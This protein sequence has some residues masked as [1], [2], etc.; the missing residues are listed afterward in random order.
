MVEEIASAL[1]S[2]NLIQAGGIVVAILLIGLM[3]FVMRIQMQM[4][5]LFAEHNKQMATQAQEQ[6]TAC[7][8][9]TVS[10]IRESS[11]AKVKLAEN[12]ATHTKTIE[13]FHHLLER[14]L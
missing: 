4:V 14:R 11:Q 9:E 6:I 7:N 8:K 12:L 2:P 13:S 5:A 3:V 10:A 1:S